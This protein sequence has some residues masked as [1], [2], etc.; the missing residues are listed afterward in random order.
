MTSKMIKFKEIV[1]L[2]VCTNSILDSVLLVFLFLWSYKS[3]VDGESVQIGD[4]LEGIVVLNL[5]SYGG[6]SDLWG[7][8]DP[9]LVSRPP[10]SIIISILQV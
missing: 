7:P 1:S 3:K 8:V 5:P 6:G 9:N 4:D 10:S 2:E